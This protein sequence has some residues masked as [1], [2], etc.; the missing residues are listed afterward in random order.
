MSDKNGNVNMK[1]EKTSCVLA[2]GYFDGVHIGHRK[3]IDEAKKLADFLGCPLA[4][5]SFSGDLRSFLSGEKEGFLYTPEEREKLLRS[6]GAE[7]VYFAPVDKEFLAKSESEFLQFLQDKY[8][9][10]GFVCGK[11]YTFGAFGKGNVEYL[12]A[13]AKD[14]GITCVAVDTVIDRTTG[15]KVS[16]TFIKSLLK[17]GKIEK[18]NEYLVGSYFIEGSVLPDR[19]VGRTIGFPTANIKC[20]SEKILLKEGVYF[21]HI[22]IENKKYVC[23]INYGARPTFALDDFTVEVHVIDYCGDLYGKTLCVCFDGYMRDIVKFAD[24]NQLT[25]QI[26]K[27]VASAKEKLKERIW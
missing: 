11:D 27:D 6:L 19:G 10:K 8:D 9:I 23:V 13:Y 16:T 18:A 2:L 26:E 12:K 22:Y 20:P 15:A 25:E 17:E 1:N 4:V 7:E 14:R 5:F 21:G 3:V 24:K